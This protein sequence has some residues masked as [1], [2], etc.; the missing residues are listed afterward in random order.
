MNSKLKSGAGRI[1]AKD[2]T[3]K[4]E[5]KMKTALLCVGLILVLI[6]AAW[7][8]QGTGRFPYPAG[9]IM[10]NNMVWAYRGAGLGTLGLILIVISGR[11]RKKS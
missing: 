9:N 5:G 3:S 8:G 1:D 6:G 4:G 7:I 10:N 11:S 2:G